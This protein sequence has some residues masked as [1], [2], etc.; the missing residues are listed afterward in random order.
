M[1]TIKEVLEKALMTIES[2]QIDYI[3]YDHKKP[4]A[5]NF[6]AIGKVILVKRMLAE[7]IGA[8]INHYLLP[9]EPVFEEGDDKRDWIHFISPIEDEPTSSQLNFLLNTLLPS[10]DG[11]SG[12][13][14]SDDACIRCFRRMIAEV[15]GYPELKHYGLL[16]KMK[17]EP[18]YYSGY[19]SKES[20]KKTKL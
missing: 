3:K 14:D 15:A 2:T 16:G 6:E 12:I 20:D 9:G 17:D 1:K 5:F 4:G 11:L 13:Q 7:L 8:D 10:C 18:L 19:Q